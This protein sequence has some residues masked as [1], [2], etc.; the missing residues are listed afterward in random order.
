[1]VQEEMRKGPWTEQEDVQLVFYV[2]MFGDRR[3]DFLAKVS[4]LKRSGKSCRLRWVNYLN[5]ALKRG[6]M[7]PQEELLVL[8]LH[9]KY[10]NRFVYIFNFLIFHIIVLSIFH[11]IESCSRKFNLLKSPKF[12]LIELYIKKKMSEFSH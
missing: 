10:G 1:M 12:S 3:W 9:S 2:K 11:I 5:P 6:K 8:Q 4:G 7:T